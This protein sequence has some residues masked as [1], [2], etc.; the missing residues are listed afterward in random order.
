MAR[1]RSDG[2]PPFGWSFPHDGP[3]SEHR[4]NLCGDATSA[5]APHPAL[6]A[7]RSCG[8]DSHPFWSCPCDECLYFCPGA[9]RRAVRAPQGT[10]DNAAGAGASLRSSRTSPGAASPRLRSRDQ[11]PVCRGSQRRLPGTPSSCAA[12]TPQLA[13]PGSVGAASARSYVVSSGSAITAPP[14]RTRSP[15]TGSRRRGHRRSCWSQSAVSRER[16]LPWRR[17]SHT[18]LGDACAGS[19]F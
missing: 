10:E 8:H 6:L 13:R 17:T 15:C 5:P 2:S 4:G 11:G 3:P 18:H 19:P 1:K 9:G 12:S 7:H 16:A 14:V